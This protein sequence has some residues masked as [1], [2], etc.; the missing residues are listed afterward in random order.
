MT[1][2]FE[3][4]AATGDEVVKE[5]EQRRERAGL[6]LVVVDLSMTLYADEDGDED[7]DNH[8]RLESK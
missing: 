4:Q 5:H 1:E 2:R 6:K 8:W 7:E 3:Q